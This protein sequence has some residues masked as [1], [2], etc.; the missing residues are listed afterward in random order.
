[1]RAMCG[2]AWGWVI[3]LAALP[4]IFSCGSDD[5]AAPSDDGERVAIAVAPAPGPAQYNQVWV[6]KY[7][8]RDARHVLILVPGSPS[9]QG[10]YET[11][12]P[13]LVREVADLAVW[14]LDRREN[15]LEDTTGFEL[16]DP[17]KAFGYYFL[18]SQVR[19]RSFTPVSDVDGA[20]VREW[21]VNVVFNDLHRVV[22]AAR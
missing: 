22:L 16:D 3:V 5:N 20:F 14:T 1:M 12:A 11:L 2:G 9:G 13:A 21:G 15:G 6:R 4:L 17:D 8:P 7:G 19:G 18:G 10:N